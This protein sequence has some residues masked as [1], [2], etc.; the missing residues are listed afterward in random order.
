MHPPCE[1]D[2]VSVGLDA[3]LDVLTRRYHR[4]ERRTI[5]S[6]TISRH[7][8]VVSSNAQ[9]LVA[10]RRTV[11]C[12]TIAAVYTPA[13][14]SLDDEAAWSVVREA[15]AGALVLAT[16]DGLDSAFVPVL[17]SDD[18]GAIYSHVAKANP[19]WRAVGDGADV[20]ALFVTASAY[21]SPTYYPSRLERPGVVPTWN[22]VAAEVRGRVTVHHDRQWK[23]SQVHALTERY[24]E[25]VNPSGGLTIWT[26]RTLRDSWRRSWA[27][28][29]RFCRSWARPNSRRTVL[30]S[31]TTPFV[32]TSRSVHRE[33]RTSRN[34]CKG[35]SPRS[36]RVAKSLDL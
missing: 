32:T 16:P 10:P 23:K 20:L 4:F 27:S 1:S 2:D 29:S 19:W 36:R 31:T 15:G 22:Y 11:V 30:R 5:N 18:R 35:E 14:F 21:V 7:T 34:A 28:R 26:S 13:K 8:L 24:E 25:V 12:G 33:S 6:L 3:G 17:V 9:S